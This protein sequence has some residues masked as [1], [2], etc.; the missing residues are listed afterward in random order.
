MLLPEKMNQFLSARA[1]N[2]GVVVFNQMTL[3]FTDFA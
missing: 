3:F 2:H 1:G